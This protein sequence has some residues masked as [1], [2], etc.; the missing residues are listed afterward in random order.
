MSNDPEVKA[1]AARRLARVKTN[2]FRLAMKAAD[3]RVQL[4]A[5]VA[6]WDR[7]DAGRGAPDRTPPEL[8]RDPEPVP[9]EPGPA[10]PIG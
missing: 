8:R 4:S 1:K 9:D 3:E 5:S 6:Y 10:A 2:V 7:E